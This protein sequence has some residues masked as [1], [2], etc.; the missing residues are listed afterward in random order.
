MPLA[1]SVRCMGYLT[2][3]IYVERE[4][5][6]KVPSKYVE[7]SGYR[8]GNWVNAQRARKDSVSI[9]RI[10]RLEAL[11]GWSWP[12]VRRQQQWDEWLNCLKE[13]IDKEGHSRVPN[14]YETEKGRRLG[15]WVNEQRA[16]KDSMPA[17]RRARLEA[18]PGW[19]W[20]VK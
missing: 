17:E 2:D 14:K 6:A 5:D 3:W 11:N 7:A 18:L 10:K 15:N 20:R 4:G 9:E 1:L 16:R 19:V 13:F 12:Y 8:L